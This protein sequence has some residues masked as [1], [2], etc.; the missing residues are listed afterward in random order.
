[1]ARN[2]KQDANLIPI[3]KGDLST[4]E[5]KRRGSLGGKKSAEMRKLRKDAKKTIQF[6]MSMDAVGSVKNN[7]ENIGVPDGAQSNMTATWVKC[8]TDWLKTGDI[9]LLEALMRYGGFDASELRKERESIARVDAMN[10]SGIPVSGEADSTR[11]EI[12][13]V[14]PDDGRGAPGASAISQ[15]EAEDIFNSRED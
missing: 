15:S 8:Y 4:E 10:K 12:M 3:Q 1:M 14:L 5:A 9:R 2:P 13:I 6:I 11:N 7:L